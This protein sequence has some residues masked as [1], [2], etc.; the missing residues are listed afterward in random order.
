MPSVQSVTCTGMVVAALNGR[1]NTSLT[2]SLC[3]ARVTIVRSRAEAE[4]SDKAKS[5]AAALS[6]RAGIEREL[7]VPG[8]RQGLTIRD[9]CGKRKP[10]RG[11]LALLPEA[12]PVRRAGDLEQPDG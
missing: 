6:G 1:A 9:F 11:A 12:H 4:P 8:M 7:R 3:C 5:A 2:A 10:A